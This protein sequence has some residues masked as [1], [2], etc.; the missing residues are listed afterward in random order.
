MSTNIVINNIIPDTAESEKLMQKYQ[1]DART[2]MLRMDCFPDQKLFSWDF[3]HCDDINDPLM[4]TM[5]KYC[6]NFDEFYRQGC[7]LILYGSV[8]IGKTFAAACVANAL[9]DEGRSVH[10]TDFSR[11]INS[12][13]GVATGK[14]KYLDNLNRYDL[15]IIDDLAAERDTSYANEIVMNVID[16]RCR[17]GK[18]L[19]VTTNLTA[20]VLFSPKELSKKR[21]FSR[22]C[23]MCIPVACKGERDRRKEK[24]AENYDRYKSI[25]GLS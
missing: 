18:P 16:S 14:Q 11:I 21:V 25:L 13:W 9:V 17:S 23:E 4:V 2:M 15:L 19:I 20:D 24:M 6:K 12:L 7:G 8:G 22:L 1:Y 5:Q 10:M 3:D